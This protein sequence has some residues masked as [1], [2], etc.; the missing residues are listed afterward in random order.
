MT[1][2]S[3]P[4][5]MFIGVAA[6]GL[7]VV[8][9]GLLPYQAAR[10]F[11]E[12]NAN[13]QHQYVTLGA[14]SAF[15]AALPTA[16]SELRGYIVTHDPSS[17]TR[18]QEGMAAMHAAESR[19]EELLRNEPGIHESFKRVQ[20]LTREKEALLKITEAAAP[21]GSEVVVR[22]ID[23]QRIRAQSEELDRAY[24]EVRSKLDGSIADEQAALNS[25]FGRLKLT[26]A[27]FLGASLAVL[28]ILY[29]VARK[30]T[31]R[32]DTALADLEEQSRISDSIIDNAPVA[33]Y[34]RDAENHALVRV[35]PRLCAMSGKPRAELLGSTG[36]P[37]GAG[38]M[39]QSLLVEEKQL[40]ADSQWVA[41]GEYE[42]ATALGDRILQVRTVLIPDQQGGVRH[43]L[44]LIEDVTERREADRAEQEFASTLEQKGK[45]LE[46]ANKELESFSYSVSH[47]LRAPLRAIEG[48]A[49]I[50]AEDNA[51]QLDDT[52]RRYLQN[53]RDGA[54]RMG[55]LIQDLLAFSRL[56]RQALTPVDC[57]T[58]LVVQAAWR[59][60]RTAHPELMAQLTVLNLPRCRGD[61]HLLEQVWMNLLD[62]ARKYSSKTPDPHITVRGE[63]SE[64]GSEV[65]FHVEDNG[66]GF[67]MRYY[68]K[69]FNVFQRLHSESQF[70]GTGVGLAIV[71]RIIVRHG[72]RVFAR[73]EPGKG[74]CFS[75]ALPTGSAT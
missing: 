41:N 48:Y 54:T 46:M 5:A 26:L 2:R 42:V 38:D 53:I 32:R 35:N 28:T 3:R 68:D 40:I 34:L 21:G 31:A 6:A 47:D 10:R 75:F 73:G 61:T 27:L 65:I 39:E 15:K 71:Q 29:R 45:A 33:M 59:T 14:L 57:E 52:G 66:A 23:R 37:F 12:A 49:S 17:L 1:N 55:T 43:I 69:L 18:Y 50:L 60:V 24:A 36:C 16:V 11:A 44:R 51:A 63:S 72:G 70:P 56:N 4:T 7:M 74:A 8:V 58:Q 64:D 19:A 20:V 67:D 13:L 25:A 62:N 22:T 30:T 9:A